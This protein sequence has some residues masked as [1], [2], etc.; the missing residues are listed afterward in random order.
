VPQATAAKAPQAPAASTSN[1]GA[2][3]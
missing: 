2:R 1:G 3:P